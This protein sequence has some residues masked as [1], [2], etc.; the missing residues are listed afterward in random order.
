[1]LSVHF[2]IKQKLNYIGAVEKQ[3]LWFGRKEIHM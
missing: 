2:G 1:M 3:A